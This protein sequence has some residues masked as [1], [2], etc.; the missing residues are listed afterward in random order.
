MEMQAAA[1][2]G[3]TMRIASGGAGGFEGVERQVET[4]RHPTLVAVLSILRFA[5]DPPFPFRLCSP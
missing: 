5:G 2:M 4:W 1:A 3:I